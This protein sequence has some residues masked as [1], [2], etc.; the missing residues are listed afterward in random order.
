MGVNLF[1]VF[2]F[3]KIHLLIKTIM[4]IGGYQLWDTRGC[5]TLDVATNNNSDTDGALC[6]SRLSR[7]TWLIGTALSY[8]M[9]QVLAKSPAPLWSSLHIPDES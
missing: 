8:D 2:Y 3:T 9:T 5:L 4:W 6:F 1:I 7:A